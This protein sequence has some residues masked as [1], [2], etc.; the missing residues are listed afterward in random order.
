MFA[1]S[2]TACGYV[3]T[4]W[5]LR[6]M[7]FSSGKALGAQPKENLKNE[8]RMTNKHELKSKEQLWLKISNSFVPVLKVYSLL[9][10]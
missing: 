1:F 4:H 3:T 8:E 7:P 10:G 5:I 6:K 2:L 9:D